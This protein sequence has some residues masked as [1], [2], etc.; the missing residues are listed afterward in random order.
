MSALEFLSD[1]CASEALGSGASVL[2]LVACYMEEMIPLRAIALASNVAFIAYGI[3]HGLAPNM[4]AAHAPAADEWL[5]TCSGT[6]P[7]WRLP[8][9]SFPAANRLPQSN[10]VASRCFIW[11]AM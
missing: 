8:G 11:S 10:K 9:T 2:V 3:A 6:L 1:I 4:A 7:E 5:P